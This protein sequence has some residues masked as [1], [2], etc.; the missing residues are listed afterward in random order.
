MESR[1]GGRDSEV[2]RFSFEMLN[3]L[4][5]VIEERQEH[6]ENGASQQWSES[7][8]IGEHPGLASVRWTV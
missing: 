6:K 1:A 4:G 5:E 2:V 8:S 7:L 3:T